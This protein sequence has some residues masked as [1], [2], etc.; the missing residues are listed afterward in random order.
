MKTDSE[1]IKPAFGPETIFDVAL[2]S[3]NRRPESSSCTIEAL[4]PIF[5]VPSTMNSSRHL[6]KLEHFKAY[7]PNHIPGY[8]PATMYRSED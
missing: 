1:A 4:S 5:S 6:E 2:K 7:D 3:A 8:V